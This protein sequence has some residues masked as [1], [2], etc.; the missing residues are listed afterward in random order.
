MGGNY[1][2]TVDRNISISNIVATHPLGI[3]E[4]LVNTT[5]GTSEI[6]RNAL[7]HA[8]RLAFIVADDSDL[9]ILPY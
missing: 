5:S 3:T 7:A 8:G 9:V 1:G 2:G 4:H 6:G